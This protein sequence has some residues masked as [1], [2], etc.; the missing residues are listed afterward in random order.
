MKNLL[1]L[2]LS[3]ISLNTWAQNFEGTI[4]WSMK[5]EVT[6]PALKAKM[7]EG[8]QKMNDPA[9]QAKMKE[10]EAKMNDPQF[11]AMM[12]AN[13]QMKEMMEK[14]MKMMKGASNGDMSG[15]MP[16]GMI[17]KLKDGNSLVTMDGGMMAGDFLR[18]KDKNE[19]IHIDRQN[20]T[21]SV[22]NTGNGAGNPMGEASKPTVTKT[23]ETTKILGY[24]CT[25]YVV[26]LTERGQTITQ[27][28]WA[29]TEIKDID[30]KALAKQRMGRGGQ[31]MF[32][33]GVD[34]IPL[35]IESTMK[36]G[37]MLMEC[38]EIKKE[39]LNASDFVI[40]SDFKEVKGMFGR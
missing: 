3:V 24:T 36:E 2:L 15:M 34:G 17:I 33:E 16:K 25:K 12:E 5:M 39:S 18:L 11:K 32:Y 29:T 31:S 14:N 23:G 19:S 1:M 30:V 20:K 7:A 28:L 10:F 26:T 35:R 27:N 37:N 38:T 13:P 4:K 6:D 21:Y 9:N 8:Q 22:M 40:P